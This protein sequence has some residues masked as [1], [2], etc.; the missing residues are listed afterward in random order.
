MKMTMKKVAGFHSLDLGFLG[1][2]Q[3]TSCLRPRNGFGIR[4][5]QKDVSAIEG[6]ELAL[7]TTVLGRP[8]YGARRGSVL[9]SEPRKMW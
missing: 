3:S 6:A 2:C 8:G 7:R 4:D 1:T 9:A 5:F